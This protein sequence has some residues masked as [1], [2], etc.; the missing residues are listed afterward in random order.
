MNGPFRLAIVGG[1]TA[2]WMAAN[3]LAQ[4]WRD[5]SVAITLIEAPEIGTIGV[6]E[7][8]TPSLKRFFE[9]VGIAEAEWM[10]ACDATYKVNIRFS[11]WSPASGIAD[12]SHPFLT[13]VDVHTEDAFTR[14]CGNR[15]LGLDV[16]T[17]PDDFFL[18]GALALQR[19]APVAPAN[20]PFRM[21]YGYHFDSG[22]LGQ[23][24]RDQAVARG[25]TH[26]S[27]HVEAVERAEGGEIA[28]L[29]TREGDRIE[30]DFFIDCSGFAGLLMQRTLEVPFH[31][32]KSNLFN[33][34]AVVVP[35]EVP[36]DLPVETGATALSAGWAWSI[37]LTSRVGNG[38]V[39]SSDFLSAD[40]AEAELRSHL[41]LTEGEAPVRHLSFRVGQLQRH[42]DRNCVAIGLAQG[43]IEP[44]E[45]TALHLVLNTVE[46]FINRF[47][48]GGFTAQHRDAF[49]ADISDRIERVRDYI[50]AH[51]KLN[52]RSDSDYWRAN[53]EN[54]ALSGNLLEILDTWF[55][56][57]D[58]AALLER[59][60][61]LSHFGSASWHCLLSGYGAYPELA[62]E[63]RSDTDFYTDRQIGAFLQGCALNF[64][65]QSAV[66]ARRQFAAASTLSL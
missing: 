56:R 58:L 43:F 17:R 64:E 6:G 11:G 49:N 37:P 13:Q 65:T 5:R 15:R 41:G 10:A 28:A 39:Y 2:G 50:V 26:L 52:T 36:A 22:L 61:G 29:R 7:G 16:P 40:E 47:E 34:A 48:Q 25:V 9:V 32:F 24:L 19:K 60:K 38:Y 53:R 8:S 3:L 31:S 63:Q 55:R 33:D 42:W 12:Y 54:D 51:Y 4:R 66:L 21:E 18:G 27:R 57:A 14:N 44:L 30:A 23:F 45:A 35:T 62:T 59:Q 46:Q 1:G 20:F